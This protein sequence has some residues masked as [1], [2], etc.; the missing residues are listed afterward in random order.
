MR[1]FIGLFL[2]LLVSSVTVFAQEQFSIKEKRIIVEANSAFFNAYFEDALQLYKKVYNK[3]MSNAN[4][5]SKIGMCYLE[6]GQ[7]EDALSYFTDV[8]E[9]ALKK[10]ELITCCQL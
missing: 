10:K 3:H 2:F 4:L 7:I 1:R 8:N 6:L 5:T 9:G